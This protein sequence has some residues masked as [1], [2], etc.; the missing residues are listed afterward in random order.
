[1]SINIAITNEK[2]GCA[3][4]TTAVNLSAILADKGYKTLLVDMD[5]QGYA[6]HYLERY[7]ESKPGVL[8]TIAG[9]PVEEIIQNTDTKRLDILPATIS[10]S[11]GEEYLTELALNGL[12]YINVLH[13]TLSP[14]SDKYD[15]IIVDSPPNGIHI[16]E[17]IQHF[18]DYLIL[19][20]I[21]DDYAI[22]SLL[23]KADE[24]IKIKSTVNSQLEILGVL[25]TMCEKTRNKMAY[26]EAIQSSGIFPC[27]DTRIRKNTTI[28]EAINAKEPVHRYNKRSNGASDYLALAEEVLNKLGMEDN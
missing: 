25:L 8:E 4:T 18:A 2:G 14:I 15:F 12:S 1:M 26:A 19:P 7:D 10:F 21:P 17:I 9:S 13:K 11:K 22:H 27:F 16:K 6:S 3:K 28:S 24:M 20:T 5:Y 23:V